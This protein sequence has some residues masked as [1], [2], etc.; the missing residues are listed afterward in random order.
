MIAINGNKYANDLSILN[1]VK[2]RKSENKILD[3]INHVG[4]NLGVR[5]HNLMSIKNDGV[6]MR[7][8]SEKKR[9]KNMCNGDFKNKELIVTVQEKLGPSLADQSVHKTIP[10][11]S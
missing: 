5:V 4:A 11:R 1:M 7:T 3:K 2:K 8:R 10:Q 6:V 9:S